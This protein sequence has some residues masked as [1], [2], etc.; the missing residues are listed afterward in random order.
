MAGQVVRSVIQ[1][2]IGE[3]LPFKHSRR[4]AGGPFNLFFKKLV[5]AFV[6]WI[7][8]GRLVPFQ[9]HLLAL[10]GRQNRQRGKR[11]VRILHDPFQESL[12]MAQETKNRGRV[13]QIGVVLERAGQAIGQ[14]FQRESQIELG[15]PIADRDGGQRQTSPFRGLERSRLQDEHDLKNGRTAQIAFHGK[16]LDEL[17]EGQILVSISTQ[18]DFADPFQ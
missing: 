8:G 4:R 12:E 9:Q 7:I 10:S 18:S 3:L 16:G 17:L 15:R 11:L 5:N 6:L 2:P 13:E 1:F 14:F